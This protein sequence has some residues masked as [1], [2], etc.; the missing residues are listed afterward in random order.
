MLKFDLPKDCSA[1]VA[2]NDF[3]SILILLDEEGD[4]APDSGRIVFR[5]FPDILVSV[6]FKSA[7]AAAAAAAALASA[8]IAKGDRICNGYCGKT[9]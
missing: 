6:L 5:I 4:S 7:E 9:I 2:N 3:L 1:A 8:L